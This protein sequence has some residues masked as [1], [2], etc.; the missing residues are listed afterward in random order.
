MSRKRSRLCSFTQNETEAV[1]QL[2]MSADV[3][4]IN[5]INKNTLESG[6]CTGSYTV[7]IEIKLQ[8]ELAF[9]QRA[10]FIV[11]HQHCWRRLIRISCRSL[12]VD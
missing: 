2:A 4:R 8:A 1:T 7:L 6:L 9:A 5:A 12:T 10:G 11:R 3:A